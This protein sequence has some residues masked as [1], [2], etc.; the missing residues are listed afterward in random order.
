MN[1]KKTRYIVRILTLDRFYY[2]TGYVSWNNELEKFLEE[3]NKHYGLKIISK[4]NEGLITIEYTNIIWEYI[5]LFGSYKK[6]YKPLLKNDER[7]TFIEQ[8]LQQDLKTMGLENLLE[9]VLEHLKKN[10]YFEY[11]EIS[12]LQFKKYCV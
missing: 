11:K 8:S 12:P 9:K 7:W 1:E 6:K 5:I 3:E 10:K 4:Q 2:G